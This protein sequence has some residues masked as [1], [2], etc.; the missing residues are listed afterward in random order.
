MT[1]YASIVELYT[2]NSLLT[3]RYRGLL[4]V[5]GHVTILHLMRY[6]I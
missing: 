6:P 2:A 4:I 3:I 5:H 1:D